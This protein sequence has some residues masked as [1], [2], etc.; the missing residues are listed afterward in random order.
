MF[1]CKR[2]SILLIFF[3]LFS[4]NAIS[5]QLNW[6]LRN[7]TTGADYAR[8]VCTDA[9]GNVYKVGA[10]SG[11]NVDFD[12]GAGTFPMSSAGSTDAYVAKYDAN[13][14][15][16]W[17]FRFGG[18]DR[19]E[20]YGVHIDPAGDLLLSG[21][22]RGSNIDVD[23]GPGTVPLTSNGDS[24]GDPG[25]GGDIFFGKYT[26]GGAYI[27]AFNIGGFEL[28]DN[29]IAITSDAASNVYVGGYFKH[30]ADFDPSAGNTTLNSATGGPIFLAKYSPAGAFQWA[31]NLGLGNADNTIFDL[32]TDAAGNVYAT[33]FY[34]GTAIDFDP[35]PA[36]APLSSNGAYEM[37]VAK[38]NT[39]GQYQFAISAGSSGNDVGRGIA[40]D[41][42]GNIYVLG[43]FN[44]TVDFDP[45]PGTAN[46]SANGGNSDVVLAKYSPT[47]QYIWAFRFGGTPGEFGWKV[48]IDGSHLFVTGGFS[49]TADMDPSA[50]VDNL[51]SSGGYDIFLGKYTLNGEYL[52]AFKIG[53]GGD[54][55]GNAV[56]SPQ[57]NVFYIVGDF[58]STNVDFDPSTAVSNMSTAGGPDAFL[59]KYTWSDNN[60]PLGTISGDVICVG[61]QAQMTFTATAGVAPFTVVYNNGTTNITQTNVQSG[62]PFN[63]TPNPTTTTTY[64][65]VSV[66]DAQRCAETNFTTGTTTVT[67]NACNGAPCD[68]WL[69]LPTQGSYAT[70]GDL[71]VTG[72]Q[73]TVEA[74]VNRVP[75]L[76][77][78]LHFGHLVSKH[79]DQSN[80]NYALQ[81]LGCEIT[82]SVTGYVA[83]AP[84]CM[85]VTDKT[86]HVAMVYD[87]A[88]LKFYRNGFLMAQT[89]ATGNMV[90][91]NL[92]TKIGQVGGPTNPFNN[93]TL[94]YTNEVRIWNVARTQAELRA[95]MAIPLANPTTQ[96]GLLAYYSFN[97]LFNKQGNPAWNATLQGGAAIG[98][99]NPV[100][101]VATD[102]CEL[103]RENIINDYSPVIA[104]DI[105]KNTIT[106][107]DATEYQP[108]DT[109]LL[110]QMKGAIID[111]TNTAAFGDVTNYRNA[112]NYEFNYV[113][114]KSGNTIELLN[115]IE[116]QYD[117]ID[118]RVQLVRVPYFQD[119]VVTDKL[120][121]LP[122]DG[123]KGGVLVFNVQN[124]LSLQRDIDVSGKGFRGGAPIRSVQYNCNIDS[125]YLAGNMGMNGNRKGEGVY[126]TPGKLS[127]R[128]KLANGGGG[129]NST[130]A[131]GAGGGNGG[132]GGEGGKQHVGGCNTN[133]T[134]GGV[135]GLGLTYSNTANKIYMGGG[136][137][138]GHMDDTPL[139]AG[140]NGGGIVIIN[141]GSITPGTFAIKS[142]GDSVQPVIGTNDDGRSGGGAGG[143]ILI[144]YGTISGNLIVEA[145][146]GR[147]DNNIA[148]PAQNLHGPGGGGGGGI[149]WINQPSA[150]ANMTINVAGGANGI[151]INQGNNAWGATPGASGST[152]FDLVMP[153][154]D[155]LFK[156]NIDSVRFN[157]LPAPNCRR[158]DFEGLAYVNTNP[159]ATWQ[160]FFGDNTTANTQNATHTY[161]SPGTYIVKLVVTDINGCKDSLLRNVTPTFL[162]F[163][164]SYQQDICNPFSVQFTGTGAT[165]SNPYWSFG[166]NTTGNTNAPVH[167]YGGENIYTVVYSV[168][169]NGCT[170]T[171][172]KTIPVQILRENVVL[173]QDTTICAGT[174]KQLRGE[175][176]LRYCWTPSTYLDNPNSQH[177]VTSTPHDMT[178]YL[179]TETTGNNLIVNGNFNNGNTGFTSQYTFTPNNVTEGQYFVGPNPQ[180]WNGGL[181]NC[182]DHTTGNGNMLLVN[183]S[184]VADVEVWQQ[185]VTVTPNTNYAF[186]TWIQA[187]WT[188]NPAQLSFAIN[189]RNLGNLITASL[190]TCTWTQFSA[191]WNSGASTTAVISIVNRNTMVQGNDFALD[192]ISFAPVFVKRD[193][194]IISVDTPL[195]RT[196]TDTTICKTT[197]VQLTATGA[198][199]Y[200]W[201]PAATLSN[202]N[203]ANPLATPVAPTQYIVSGINSFGCE[204]KDTVNIGIYP[205]PVIAVTDNTEICGNSSIP[206]SVSGGVSY[207]WSPAA[208]LSD[209][210]SATPIATPATDTRYYVTITDVNGCTHLDSVD[211]SIRPEPLFAIANGVSIC[212][213]ESAQL[214][215]SGGVTYNWSPAT[216]LNNSTIANPIATPLTTTTYTVNVSEPV[217]NRSAVLSTTI[218]VEV[219]VVNTIDNTAICEGAN[220]QLTTTG[221]QTYSWT[222]AGTLSDPTSANPIATPTAPTQYIVTGTTATGCVAK[223]TVNISFHPEAVTSVSDDA[224][225]CVNTS[226]TL[227]ASGGVSY[228]WTPGATLS[229]PS[230]ANPVATPVQN[231]MYYVTIT[232]VNTCT[233]LDS[234]K[235]DIKP[236]PI[237]AVSGAPGV[238]FDDTVQLQASGGNIYNWQASPT[239][240]ATNIPN[241]LVYPTVTTTYSVTITETVCNESATLTKQVTVWQRPDVQASKAN[242]ID[243]SYDRSQLSAS[244]AV[245]YTW[246]PA[247][248]LNNPGIRNPVAM[249]SAETQYTVKG[250]DGNGCT[251]TDTITVKFTDA[252]KGDYLMPTGFTPNNDGLNDCYGI[253]YWGVIEALEFSIYNR[254]GERVFYTTQKGACWDG[255]YKGVKQDS[256][257]FVY[258]INAKTNCE[259]PVFRKGTFVLIR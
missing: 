211:I 7:G 101:P 157:I 60:M 120:T 116:R 121:C 5:Q 188:P 9:A 173:T 15:F 154:D 56:F 83:L 59:A 58:A 24:G 50:N 162:D 61:E 57:N 164:F 195:V 77:N 52:C 183:G 249:P 198:A 47:G 90:N 98:Q 95:S 215:A 217:C 172:T 151:H 76:N 168:L 254:W 160:W 244:G 108:G 18:A 233:Y 88:T 143:T 256:G 134:N 2:L 132:V 32:K 180:A 45:G 214:Q 232:D 123:Q 4:S 257:V 178:Y 144:S 193:S 142:N 194:V 163:D 92:L 33:G 225:I 25:Y 251:N 8:N 212:V 34:Q 127:G 42:A 89:A 166:D 124:S 219:P 192:D 182:Q 44:G 209:P 230:V 206:L 190:P 165:T 97:N 86:Y 243:C 10:F 67:V 174:T 37:F 199:T 227:S 91:N 175:T 203:I 201:T 62:V 21:Y 51:V 49:G 94:G 106:V 189:G 35:S 137:G 28:Y 96:P 79:T 169:S 119:L 187:L 205:D 115:T 65:L 185:T 69:R 122:W 208:T 236:R 118:G 19:D 258:M 147:G 39:A 248:S 85:P 27:W 131:G 64:T 200:S 71:D 240:N 150:A 253:K 113:K 197:S 136:G 46:L 105:C 191:T 66:K 252:N 179:I 176:G 186:S 235:I 87:G 229:N 68:S 184:P 109:V 202:A 23:P 228:A 231:T 148:A 156:P 53:G 78:G 22:F 55:F 73:I 104:M 30:T 1:S 153:V 14:N 234:V 43:D 110:I 152:L 130:N 125:F 241:P 48:A 93:Q 196:R 3:L 40:L 216:G 259:K 210:T 36:T 223:D 135:G 84:A 12:P 133:F 117:I 170:D 207:L 20:L 177:P 80:V 111:T 54:D 255:T 149:V 13:G 221:A 218:T 81:L 63:I 29:A 31:F 139:G 181:D 146:G 204:A 226:T 103:V 82:T 17:A 245:T 247:A 74:L 16:I 224:E 11:A 107:A 75:P 112:G 129:G 102:S 155:V 213:G 250:T 41:A 114:A 140:G 38:Y 145:K 239:I 171:I 70:V 222:P 72:N 161:T 238:C 99:T 128:G 246:S 100:C 138:S 126:F 237:F 6:A 141:T 220:I 242:D 26:A 158:F 167:V 159:V